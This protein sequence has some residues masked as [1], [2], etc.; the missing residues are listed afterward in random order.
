MLQDWYCYCMHHFAINYYINSK[1]RRNG[2]KVRTQDRQCPSNLPLPPALKLLTFFKDL[3]SEYF[4]MENKY[5]HF[6]VGKMQSTQL[7]KRAIC[8]YK[9]LMRNIIGSHITCFWT[10]TFKQCILTINQYK[11]LSFDRICKVQLSDENKI[12]MDKVHVRKISKIQVLRFHW[13]RVY[14]D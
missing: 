1:Y 14:N 12:L 11:K 10:N 13:F 6:D 4:D 7:A 2:V 9:S 8:K 3:I 5:R